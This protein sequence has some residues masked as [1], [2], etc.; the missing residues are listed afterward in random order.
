MNG[1]S[2]F[3]S[4]HQGVDAADGL[5]SK[6][7]TE[8]IGEN[9]VDDEEKKEGEI[10]VARGTDIVVDEEEEEDDDGTYEGGQSSVEE[11]FET[12]FPEHIAVGALNS[13]ESKPSDGD[14][15]ETEPEVTIIYEE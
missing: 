1:S 5:R 4:L 3:F 15:A 6:E 8:R 9:K 13:V 2:S 12:G 10:M 14:D 7:E 11:F